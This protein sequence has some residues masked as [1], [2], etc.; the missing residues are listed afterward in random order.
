MG[1]M[2]KPINENSG[3]VA[4]AGTWWSA[5]ALM[6]F[7]CA[8][9]SDAGQGADDVDNTDDGAVDTGTETDTGT[10]A[11]TDTGADPCFETPPECERFLE[12]FRA[13]APEQ[14]EPELDCL[15]GTEAE[16]AACKQAC[17]DGLEQ[18]IEARPTEPACHESSCGLGE[19]DPDAPYGPV[20]DGA[21]PLYG[22]SGSWQ[23]PVIQ[24]LGLPGHFCAPI[25]GGIANY[26]PDPPQ[27][28][29]EGIGYLWVAPHSL[30]VSRCWV[31]PTLYGG[32]QCQCGARCQP[33]GNPDG[34]GNLR[35]IC[36]FE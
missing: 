14:P 16:A 32:N 36:T 33:H 24:P 17:I 26:C 35:G 12:C 7:A 15:C 18:A 23:I 3:G 8:S 2:I 34:E 25:H 31:D 1:A 6:L 5:A 20:I 29:A 28:T 22:P 19:L 9:P 27:T 13:V 11:D 30:C 4:S 10:E 21:C